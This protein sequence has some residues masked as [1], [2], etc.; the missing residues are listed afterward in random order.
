MVC[1]VYALLGGSKVNE[2]ITKE[3]LE[4]FYAEIASI[5]DSLH[6]IAEILGGGE[7]D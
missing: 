6:R 7:K 2:L 3:V 1:R 4:K 5:A